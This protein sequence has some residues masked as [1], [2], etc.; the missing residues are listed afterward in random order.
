MDIISRGQEIVSLIQKVGDI[1]LYKKIVEL[2]GDLVKLSQ[3]NFACQRKCLELNEELRLKKSL[4]HERSVY[5]AEGDNIP[6]CP[7]CW[8]MN[9]KLI[10]LFGQEMM[11]KDTE[12]WSCHT[13]HYD[14][15]AEVA[16]AFAPRFDRH[17][18]R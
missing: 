17:R 9:D 6:F 13:C 7:R 1:E 5:Y 15:T 18:A 3:E 16:A 10:H 11:N 4:R 12:S 14:F 8:E 2:Q